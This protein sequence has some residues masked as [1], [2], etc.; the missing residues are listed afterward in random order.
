MRKNRPDL[1]DTQEIVIPNESID[2]GDDYE[3]NINEYTNNDILY[4]K[5]RSK[6]KDDFF[7]KRNVIIISSV[8]FFVILIIVVLT[9]IFSNNSGTKVNTNLNT[10]T[11][12][13]F[14]TP[15]T[16]PTTKKVYTVIE[17]VTEE[18]NT[19][20][21]TESVE[22]TTIENTTGSRLEE[23]TSSTI[24]TEEPSLIEESALEVEKVFLVD[25]ILVQKNE[26]GSIVVK[27]LGNF[28]GYNTDELLTKVSVTTSTG[29]PSI[30]NTNL[31]DGC[32]TFNLILDG[33][34]GNLE[35]HADTFNYFNK[36]E[37]L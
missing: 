20:N 12:S 14:S 13:Y 21:T 15:T 4:K 16:V 5:G 25:N 30:S 23:T 22:P 18:E 1:A 36:V 2:Y 6:T 32:F 17:N 24:E 8:A 34:D 19:E 3:V 27:V 10:T 29:T 31:E 33:C 37:N 28:S 35:I 9:I 26:N 7:L 11:T